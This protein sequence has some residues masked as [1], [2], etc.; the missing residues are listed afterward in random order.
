MPLDFASFD[1]TVK[2]ARK[3]RQACKNLGIS[4]SKCEG[5]TDVIG[6]ICSDYSQ[7]RKTK[8]K[9]TLS[10]WQL[11]IREGMAGKTWNPQRIKD[12]AKLY[13]EGKCPTGV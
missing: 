5:L 11:C 9:R 12:L 13:R 2:S 7:P 10:K 8:G 4:E 1:V 3:L 6:N